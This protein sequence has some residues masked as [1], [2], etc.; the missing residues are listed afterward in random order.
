MSFRV[1]FEIRKSD[2]WKFERERVDLAEVI[3]REIGRPVMRNGRPWWLCPFHEDRKPSLIARRLEDGRQRWK[4]YGCSARRRRRIRHADS[5][6]YVPRGEEL[7]T[8]RDGSPLDGDES[9][10]CG[11]VQARD[12][13]A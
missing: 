2:D 6:D 5:I 9:R 12:E 10:L 1:P 7:S 8:R 3:A 11:E 4:C 13:A